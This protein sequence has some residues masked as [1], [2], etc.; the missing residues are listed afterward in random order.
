[1]KNIG[2]LFVLVSKLTNC[3][4]KDGEWQSL[5]ADDTLDGWHIFQDDGSKK[6]WVVADNTLIFNG[7]C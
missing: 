2:L 3:T 1:M 7:V 6:G 5:L 4:T